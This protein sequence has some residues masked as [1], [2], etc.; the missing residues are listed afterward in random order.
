MIHKVTIA[1]DDEVYDEAP[2]WKDFLSVYVLDEMHGLI[3]ELDLSQKTIN[4]AHSV[5]D[6]IVLHLNA[7]AEEEVKE[8]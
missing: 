4:S 5:L 6:K 7:Y 3:D 1:W 2:T 8:E